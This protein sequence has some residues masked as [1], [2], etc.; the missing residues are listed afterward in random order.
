MTVCFFC[1]DIIFMV[2]MDDGI[3]LGSNN[4][5]LQDVIKESQD[6]G[7]YIE[8]QGHPADYVGVNI[9]KLQDGS[10]DFTQRPLNNSIIG[11]AGLKDAKVKPVLAKVSLRLHTLRMS[12]LFTW[13]STTGLQFASSTT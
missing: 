9:K 2:Y 4:L 8:D 7:L 1:D 11:D 13:T 5:Q 6:R 12:L 3:F 10:D